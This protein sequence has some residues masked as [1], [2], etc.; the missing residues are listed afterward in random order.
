MNMVRFNPVRDLDSLQNQVN[1]LFATVTDDWGLPDARKAMWYPAV[2]VWETANEVI[3][4]AE[5]PGVNPKQLDVRLENNVLTIRGERAVERE[6][7]GSGEYCHRLE[8]QH[9]TFS[10][11]FTIPGFVDDSKIKAEYTDGILKV[12][13]PKKETARPRRIELAS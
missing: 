4:K 12:T 10:R 2:D 1:R 13:L 5:I 7:N 6:S 11:S 8:R 9:G 3:V